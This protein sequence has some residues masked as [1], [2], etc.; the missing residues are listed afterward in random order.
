MHGFDRVADLS[1]YPA[2]VR[3][4]PPP[5][6]LSDR[7][8]RDYLLQLQCASLSERAIRFSMV[9]L[10]Q[11]QVNR[12]CSSSATGSDNPPCN[13]WRGIVMKSLATS[14]IAVTAMFTGFPQIARAAVTA[15][16]TAEVL[17]A[18]VLP[19][20]PMGSWLTRATLNIERSRASG[21]SLTLQEAMPWQMAIRKGDR[22]RIP[23]EK[24]SPGTL[25]LKELAIA[26]S[27]RRVGRSKAPA[28]AGR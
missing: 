14:L 27:A 23:C 22:F 5:C 16:C 12:A 13:Y 15:R 17:Q 10:R 2:G 4:H 20:A 11:C 6:N 9:S 24:A 8:R 26:P 3:Q 18:E 28:G 1:K 21:F 25:D 19:F 7:H